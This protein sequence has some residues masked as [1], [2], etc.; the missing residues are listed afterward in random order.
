MFLSSFLSARLLFCH[1]SPS[2]SVHSGYGGEVF[3]ESSVL[4][5]HGEGCWWWGGAMRGGAK[6]ECQGP[7]TTP[8]SAT[9]PS[10]SQLGTLAGFNPSKPAVHCAP[11]GFEVFIF[12]D[13]KTNSDA[14]FISDTFFKART[15]K[16]LFKTPF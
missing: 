8:G 15:N 2:A 14:Y 13:R 10:L 11:A 1:F 7:G 5:W 3:E 6:G 16:V 12:T 9:S 4:V